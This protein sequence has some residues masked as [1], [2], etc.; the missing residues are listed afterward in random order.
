M[1]IYNPETTKETVFCL[2]V[3]LLGKRH[4]VRSARPDLHVFYSDDRS[5]QNLDS[6]CMESSGFVRL[7]FWVDTWG[8]GLAY[9]QSQCLY[10]GTGLE[11]P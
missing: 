9:L 11:N 6:Q 4:D 10:T 8:S 5:D 2:N 7:A 3:L 1:K